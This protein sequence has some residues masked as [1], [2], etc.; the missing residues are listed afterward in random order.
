M[1]PGLQRAIPAAILAFAISAAL[2]SLIQ[3]LQMGE[4]YTYDSSVT[5]VVAP[6]VVLFAFIWGMGG[7]DPRMSEHAHAPQESDG[8]AIVP[9]AETH[10]DHH[11]PY[12]EANEKHPLRVLSGQVW[13]VGT[14]VLVTILGII[15]FAQLPT[16]LRLD[17]TANPMASPAQ[18]AL[19]ESFD[20]P[21]G[22]GT[23]Q[24]DKLS[25]F[26]G[27]IAF[28]MISLLVVAGLLGLLFYTLNQGVATVKAL[29]TTSIDDPENNATLVGQAAHAPLRA[30][31]GGLHIVGRGA[32]RL[33][34]A[35]KRGLPS[36][37][38][39]K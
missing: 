17:T 2:V 21:L 13:T 34:R 37:F 39:Q 7:L 3:R 19:N 24:A 10:E 12:E 38:G 28:T 9:V 8:L 1:K 18:N 15:A 20:L 16:G 30:T 5:L 22:M 32:G 31:R 35:L 14:V 11:D 25:V 23:F 27:F 4:T 36:F 26:L 6:F 29:P 33:A